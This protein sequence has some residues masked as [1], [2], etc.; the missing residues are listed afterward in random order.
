MRGFLKTVGFVIGQKELGEKDKIITLLTEKHGKIRVFAKGIR[1]INSRRLG[2][3]ET[4][5][6]IKA[7]IFQKNDQFYLG[8]TEVFKSQPEIRKNLVLSAS[9]LSMCELIDRL[10]AENQENKQVYNLFSQTLNNLSQK[11]RVEI[12]VIFEV[13]LLQ[14]LG[15]G[16]PN[17]VSGLL[18]TKKWP[19]VQKIVSRHLE[20]VC[21]RKINGLKIFLK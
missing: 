3:L 6:K 10:T 9:L 5:N 15:F 4:G 16:I 7:H 12:L 14:L 21:E 20:T 1:N 18:A 13:K 19:E 2:S 11:K 17:S 8:E